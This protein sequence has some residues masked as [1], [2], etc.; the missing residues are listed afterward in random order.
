MTSGNPQA[1]RCASTRCDSGEFAVPDLAPWD[2]GGRDEGED[3][4]LIHEIVQRCF[5]YRST[6][7]NLVTN[8]LLPAGY[9]Y[10]TQLVQQELRVEFPTLDRLR[11]ASCV[12]SVLLQLNSLYGADAPRDEC[13]RLK[14]GAGLDRVQHDLPRRASRRSD[15][16]T[17]P[18]HANPASTIEPRNDHDLILGQLHLACAHFHNAL[19]DGGFDYTQAR[20]QNILHFQWV[21][22]HDL[23]KRLCGVSVIE[24]LLSGDLPP[25]FGRLSGTASSLPGEFTLAAFQL[26]CSML[27]PVAGLNDVQ[28]AVPEAKVAAAAHSADTHVG[29]S[30]GLELVGLRSLSER[31]TVQWNR[32]VFV[33]D[34]LPP[35]M[36]ARLDTD[37][38]GVTEASR[39]GLC[40]AERL[41]F[42][43]L[44]RG[45]EYGL[46]SGQLLADAVGLPIHRPHRN[47]PLWLYILLEAEESEGGMQ[48]GA[49]GARL[50]AETFLTLLQRSPISILRQDWRPE[51]VRD[52][53]QY[54][55]RAWLE[56]A[57]MAL[58]RHDLPF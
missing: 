4:D 53:G 9:T 28:A 26:P 12:R 32:F 8:P 15:D 19:I 11:P 14:F 25:L 55:L 47:M 46:P 42:Q 44:R 24:G 16:L 35:L 45:W 1:A 29:G 58:T 23:L 6:G 50:V 38:S 39:H 33:E 43:I 57:A 36:T 27:R 30:V 56:A 13:G 37:L 3:I 2:P 21:V 5:R 20:E 51:R 22:L 31:R 49:L 48:L 40:G 18:T 54:G 52:G 10:F 17:D 7:P 34:S 41:A